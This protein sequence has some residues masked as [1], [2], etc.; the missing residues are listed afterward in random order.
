VFVP[1]TRSLLVSLSSRRLKT[2]KMT[3]HTA[4]LV[5]SLM[6]EIIDCI[7]LLSKGLYKY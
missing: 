5:D 1:G 2:L 7:H 3:E 4:S 6:L